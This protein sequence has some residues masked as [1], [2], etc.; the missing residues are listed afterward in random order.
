[1]Q[2]YVRCAA[3]VVLNS[4]SDNIRSNVVPKLI[5][6][7]QLCNISP[8]LPRSMLETHIPYAILRS[9]YQQHHS[10][11]SP[12]II[13]EVHTPS[14]RQSPVISLNHASPTI[15]QSRGG[16]MPAQ[17][18]Q[19]RRRSGP[20][21]YGS[22]RK[23]KFVEGSSSSGGGGGQGPSPLPRFAVSRSGPLLYK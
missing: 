8:Y 13:L 4:C 22:S 2:R 6:M 3:A 19:E 15:K 11:S 1:M 18:N 23:V 7:D 20:L 16:N 14:P 12:N 21:D 17:Q 10:N 5:F 9:I